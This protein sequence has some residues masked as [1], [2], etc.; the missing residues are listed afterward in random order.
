MLTK[1]NV[2]SFE[3]E[4]SGS[5][6]DGH[7]LN[8]CLPDCGAVV[9]DEHKLGLAVPHGFHGT[10]VTYIGKERVSWE[11]VQMYLPT[12]YFP[13]LMTKVSLSLVFSEVLSFF[14]MMLLPIS[15]QGS[16]QHFSLKRQLSPGNRDDRL[17]LILERLCECTLL[18]FCSSIN[19]N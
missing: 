19:N 3:V 2:V 6:E 1:F 10:L 9:W 16:S 15:T 8:L 11:Y 14:P 12:V 5:T 13:D 17:F 4:N 7:I 18:T